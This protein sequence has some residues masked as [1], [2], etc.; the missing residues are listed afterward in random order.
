MPAL[1]WTLILRYGLPALAVAGALFWAANFLIGIGEANIQEKWDADVAAHEAEVDRLEAIIAQKEVEHRA[2]T[3][4]ISDELVE[5]QTKFAAELAALRID[6]GDR[7]RESDSRAEIYQRLADSGATQRAN[8]ASYAAQLDR[9][10]VE[11]RQVVGELRAT[12]VQRDRQLRL[13]GQQITADR[14]LI[15]EGDNSPSSE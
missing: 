1:P 2:E 3:R 15:S 8:L 5:T 7:L 13:L 10:L 11:G 4:R 9:S 6:F 14:E 12:I